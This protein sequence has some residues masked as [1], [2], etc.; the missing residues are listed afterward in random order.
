MIKRGVLNN[1]L[2]RPLKF[3]EEF[4]SL[5]P[6][7]S[8]MPTNLGLG[9]TAK[10]MQIIKDYII[11][12]RGQTYRIAPKLQGSTLSITVKKIYDFLYHHIQYSADGLEQNVRS[13]ACSWYS[14][15]EGIDCKSYT[16]FAGCILSSLGIKFYIRKIKQP[17]SNPEH[18]SHVYI[19]VPINQ[20]TGDLSQGYQVVDPTKHQ[21]TEAVF[22]AKNDIYMSNKMPHI[23][24]NAP[25]SSDSEIFE[26]R[27]Q[28]ISQT[29]VQAFYDFIAFLT[30]IGINKKTLRAAIELF[31]K[32]RQDGI[33]PQFG[34]TNDGFVI[35]QT[36]FPFVLP[37]D[38][39]VQFISPYAVAR[40][41]S[42]LGDPGDPGDPGTATPGQ[43]GTQIAAAANDLITNSGFW[44]NTIG[45]VLGN[46]WNLSCWG[47]SNNPAQSA[48]EVQVDAPFYFE[49]SGL[50]NS[51]NTANLKK[52]I[53][54]VYPYI[55]HRN[56]GSTN[57]AVANCTRKGDKA[58]YVAMKGYYDKVIQAIKDI[59]NESG[60]DLKFDGVYTMTGNYNIPTLSGYH[61][62]RIH[63]H[64]TITDL[65]IPIFTVIAPTSVV[66][67]P[68]IGNDPNGNGTVGDPIVTGT[69]TT[70][71]TTTTTTG[72]GTGN[73][74]TNT[75]SGKPPQFVGITPDAAPS[76]INSYMSYLVNQKGLDPKWRNA[77]WR[78]EE[79][80][81]RKSTIHL[82]P[83]IV[84]DALNITSRIDNPRVY[85]TSAIGTVQ[86]ASLN[87]VLI[88]VVAA[89]GLFM[90]NK[91]LNKKSKKTT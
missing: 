31:K 12:Y 30:K 61:N 82:N 29:A 22:L 19:V 34:I 50:A 49:R 80:T 64:E 57:N 48:N 90:L 23:G 42:G 66:V 17:G 53:D 13:P 38:T 85:T 77:A 35:G 78:K 86:K 84:L 9:S 24:L 52:F 46:G 21:N 73:T 18:F 25:D 28:S 40:S 75:S 2:F 65:P 32:Y 91:T 16:V 79:R 69:G 41:E 60:G 3:G 8:C 89:G 39:G 14:R 27:R 63:P 81:I 20:I 5:I 62:D 37:S 74:T 51:L 11:K 72:A 58:G 67:D 4:D 71:T 59:L 70:T 88:A 26:G 1:M 76:L 55:Q 68:S 15:Y 45:A 36:L 83:P 10:T 43:L 33:D 44:N 56:W 54:E 6:K 47:S 87:P 7:F